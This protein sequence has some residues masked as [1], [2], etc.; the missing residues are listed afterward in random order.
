MPKYLFALVLA[1]VVLPTVALAQIDTADT[2]LS[3]APAYPTVTL[4]NAGRFVAVTHVA[5]PFQWVLEDFSVVNAGTVF[6]TPM[7]QLGT[8]KVDVVW[9]SQRASCYVSVV[10][11]PGYGEP[12]TYPMYNQPL[13]GP[14]PNVTLTSVLYPRLPNTGFEPKTAVALATTLVI[15]LAAFIALYP[16]VRKAFTIVLR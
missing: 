12:W 16:H 1:V 10:S 11:T 2:R 15:L 7:H 13:T 3:C 8:H 9:G 14:G 6:T 4:G 5:G